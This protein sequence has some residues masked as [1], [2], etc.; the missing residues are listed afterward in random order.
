MSAFLKDKYTVREARKACSLP[1]S[2]SVETWADTL[3]HAELVR[4]AKE[5]ERTVNNCNK[6]RGMAVS[7]KINLECTVQELEA[8]NNWLR[9]LLNK[10]VVDLAKET[11]QSLHET[12]SRVWKFDKPHVS[13]PSNTYERETTEMIQRSLLDEVG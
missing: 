9:S 5:L 3:T 11:V 6:S 2:G 12:I 1:T 4:Y 8:E 7:L 10:D 13:Q